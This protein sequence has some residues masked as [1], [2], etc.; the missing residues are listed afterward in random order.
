MTLFRPL[1]FPVKHTGCLLIAPFVTVEEKHEG[2]SIHLN[3]KA[4]DSQRVPKSRWIRAWPADLAIP[5]SLPVRG[6]IITNCRR[7]SIV[8]GKGTDFP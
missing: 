8:K 6:R 5:G 4:Y 3:F 7:D 1:Y 2:V